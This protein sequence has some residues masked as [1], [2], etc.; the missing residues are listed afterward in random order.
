MVGGGFRSFE[1]DS[2]N[3]EYGSGAFR[4]PDTNKLLLGFSVGWTVAEA[5]RLLGRFV[6]CVGAN[7]WL[8]PNTSFTLAKIVKIG[9]TS[10]ETT[11]SKLRFQRDL[12]F[13]Y[14]ISCLCQI[15]FC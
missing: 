3:P 2:K 6:G 15:T 11:P 13:K 10:N 5:E 9:L 14:L 4:G 12:S 1:L 8:I 7:P